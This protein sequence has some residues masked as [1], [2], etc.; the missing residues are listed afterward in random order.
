MWFG[1]FPGAGLWLRFGT[2]HVPDRIVIGE[3]KLSSNPRDDYVVVER[4]AGRFTLR[5]GSYVVC[6]F[7][8]GRSPPKPPQP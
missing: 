3:G 5:H 8:E 2:V 4:V 7:N 1:K 6:V